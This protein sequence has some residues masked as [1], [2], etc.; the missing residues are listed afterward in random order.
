[1]GK[2]QFSRYFGIFEV[3]FTSSLDCDYFDH[4]DP[5]TQ[6]VAM[7][8]DLIALVRRAWKVWKQNPI[9]AHIGDTAHISFH[10]I[11]PLG[12]TI[13]PPRRGLFYKNGVVSYR[14]KTLEKRGEVCH[15][16]ALGELLVYSGKDNLVAKVFPSDQSVKLEGAEI[17]IYVEFKRFQ[18]ETELGTGI[19]ALFQRVWEEITTSCEA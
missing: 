10:T 8:D 15:N 11:D 19:R 17:T 6:R 1:M 18:E 9:W 4:Y 2:V 16:F 14:G 7:T 13:K 3:H 12:I 5:R